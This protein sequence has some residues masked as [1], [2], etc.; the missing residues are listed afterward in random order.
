M[1][2]QAEHDFIQKVIDKYEHQQIA[3]KIIIKNGFTVLGICP[4]CK[5]M[6][7][8][9]YNDK[10]CGHCATPLDWSTNE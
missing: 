4:Q 6:I 7:H 1:I 8:S 5:G 9:T 3:Q 10:W 2:N